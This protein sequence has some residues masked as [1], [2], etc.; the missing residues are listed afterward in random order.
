M[1]TENGAQK[2]KYRFVGQGSL[3][4]TVLTSLRRVLVISHSI[5]TELFRSQLLVTMNLSLITMLN[6]MQHELSTG[7]FSSLFNDTKSTNLKFSNF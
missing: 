4:T 5:K 3:E 6:I 2:C 1:Y 7:S